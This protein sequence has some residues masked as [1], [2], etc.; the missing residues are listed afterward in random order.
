MNLLQRKRK[1]GVI[2]TPEGF[3]KL[4]TAKCQAQSWENLDKRYTLEDL[5]DRTGLDPDTLMKV[6]HCQVGVDKQTLKTC[7]RAFNLLLEPSDYQLPQTDEVISNQHSIPNLTDWGEAPDISVFLGRT[8]ELTTLK[9]WILEENCRVVTLLGMNGM[10][11]TSL[12]V[13]LA[14]QIQDK[15]EF[16]IWRSLR[17]CPPVKDMPADLIQ[18]LSK[19]QKT[20]LSKTLDGRISQLIYFFKN[21]R[22]LLILDNLDPILQDASGKYDTGYYR[23]SDDDYGELIR[24]LAETVH[25]TCLVLTSQ[26]TP[27]QMRP[28]I[29]EKLPVR[30]LQIKGLEVREIEEIFKT[31]GA[32]WGSSDNWHQLI[33]SYAGN[34][35]V[36]NI[37]SNKIYNLFYGNV[38]EF[39]NQKIL[40]FDEIS[41]MIKEDFSRLSYTEEIIIQWLA[42]NYQPASFAE[43]RS[44]LSP[45]IPP[46]ELLD[47][48]E[49][50]QERSLV[51]KNATLLSV[52]P[53][54]REYINH[55]LIKNKISF[56]IK[57]RQRQPQKY[58]SIITREKIKLRFN[59]PALT[60]V[61]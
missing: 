49:S 9:H 38:S 13:K 2:L 47:A 50:L 51:D 52:S 20:N 25:Q 22:C 6:F 34:P 18:V 11:K 35:L 23:Q 27:K 61:K 33:E 29:G 31:K 24:R 40:V 56:T 16:V 28:L 44:Q 43:L 48:L 37:V 55:Q 58:R 46:Q 8:A 15:F 17:N 41:Q 12:S 32:F 10:G 39:L 42:N 30:S 7:F 5:S 4:Q 36:L 14:E 3:Q 60:V 1:R 57:S 45:A 59:I 53:M 54:I 26:E 21:A 19:G